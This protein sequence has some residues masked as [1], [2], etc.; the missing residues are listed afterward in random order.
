MPYLNFDDELYQRG[1]LTT[2][3][4]LM[5]A[6]QHKFVLYF[7]G[8]E[9]DIVTNNI[10]SVKLDLLNGTMQ[11][12]VQQ[13]VHQGGTMLRTIKRLAGTTGF[14]LLFM[15]QQGDAAG[16]ELRGFAKLK[17]H[18]LK[19]DYADGTIVTH[20]LTFSFEA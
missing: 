19:L 6:L 7:D 4:I 14:H 9:F 12:S 15:T 18:E 8:G 13:P 11:V 10:V 5:P 1:P 20:E 16:S 3:G 2:T 17:N